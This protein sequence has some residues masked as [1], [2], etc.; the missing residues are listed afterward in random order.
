MVG[1]MPDSQGGHHVDALLHQLHDVVAGLASDVRSLDKMLRGSNGAAGVL[2]QARDN[3]QRL[4][5][6]EAMLEKLAAPPAER[7][8][9]TRARLRTIA[10]VTVAL[11]ALAGSALGV[12]Q[13]VIGG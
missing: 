3:R 2:E 11:A 10:E 5:R 8:K 1:P 6:V 9:T 7:E 12:M 13:L 4:E